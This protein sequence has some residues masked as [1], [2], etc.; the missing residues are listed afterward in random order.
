MY[1]FASRWCQGQPW[2]QSQ[3]HG[4]TPGRT[5]W[6]DWYAHCSHTVTTPCGVREAFNFILLVFYHKCGCAVVSIHCVLTEIASK[7]M[8][9]KKININAIDLHANTALHLAAQNG[10]IGVS[11][12]YE[13]Q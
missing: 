5:K 10:Q 8:R 13:S 11:G 12:S 3:E 6:M 1:F 4:L 2:K 7:L 9:A